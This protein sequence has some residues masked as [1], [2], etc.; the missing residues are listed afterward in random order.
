MP[1]NAQFAK[2]NVIYLF[3]KKIVHS[4]IILIFILVY[5]GIQWD[6]SNADTLGP[7]KCVLISEVS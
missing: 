7:L 6:S 2:F 3:V 5:S 1:I 4:I